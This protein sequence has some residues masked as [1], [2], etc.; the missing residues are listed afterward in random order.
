MTCPCNYQAALP[1]S[2]TGGDETARV[3]ERDVRPEL[4]S[5]LPTDLTTLGYP[6]VVWV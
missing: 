1:S 3:P 4:E 5:R 6:K 2:P